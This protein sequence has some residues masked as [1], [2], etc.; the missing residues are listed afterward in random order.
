MQHG[1]HQEHPIVAYKGSRLAQICISSASSDSRGGRADDLS[2]DEVHLCAKVVED[3][4][5]LTA[6]IAR[7]HD[8]KPAPAHHLVMT[9][10]LH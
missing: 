10:L 7:T 4:G 5:L 3:A 2:H 1:V 8:H 9:A 6:D